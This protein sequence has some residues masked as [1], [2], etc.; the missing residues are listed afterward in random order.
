MVLSSTLPH[1][2]LF[3]HTMKEETSISGVQSSLCRVP[4]SFPHLPKKGG[5]GLGSETSISSVQDSA[6]FQAASPLPRSGG[7]GLFC[8]C[9]VFSKGEDCLKGVSYSQPSLTKQQQKDRP[10][11]EFEARGSILQGKPPGSHCVPVMSHD[12]TELLVSVDVFPSHR[13]S[14]ASLATSSCD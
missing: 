2:I 5:G 6:E 10:A 12:W 11:C 7:L 3:D 14:G 8:C 1:I 13:T 9:L 4:G